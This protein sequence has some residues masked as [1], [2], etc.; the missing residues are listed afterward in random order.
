[1]SSRR[2]LDVVVVGLGVVGRPL[3]DQLRSTSDQL[4]ADRGLSFRIACLADKSGLLY[5][6]GGLAK[7]AIEAALDA[8]L[9]GKSIGDLASAKSLPCCFSELATGNTL[10]VDV[11]AASNMAAVWRDVLAAGAGVVLANKLPLCETWDQ[12]QLLFNHPQVRYEATVG[13]GLPVLSTLRSLLVTGDT[14]ARIDGV[15]SGTLGYL[16]GRLSAGVAFSEALAEAIELGYAEPDPS[17]DL[18]GR[19]VARKAII[20]ARSAGWHVELSDVL[21]DGFITEDEIAELSQASKAALLDARLKSQFDDVVRDDN[22]L[23]YLA[24]VSPEGIRVGLAPVPESSAFASLVGPEN[25]VNVSTGRYASYPL[26]IS[27]PGA[28]PEV[29]AAGVLSDLIDLAEKTLSKGDCA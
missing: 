8:K 20:L 29:T 11:T 22:T 16:A 25:R 5:S 23:R 13:A 24:R 19:D 6:E 27:G 1:M 14:V 15:L 7:P 9:R 26:G 3:V 4:K 10:F 18:S 17:E 12:S 28:G 2:C 21:L